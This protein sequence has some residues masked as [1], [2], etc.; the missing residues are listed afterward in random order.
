[1]NTKN[2]NEILKNYDN[3]NL[4]KESHKE[5]CG[6]IEEYKEEIARLRDF[7]RILIGG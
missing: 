6:V 3:I 7:V 2:V 4:W 5:I 1:M